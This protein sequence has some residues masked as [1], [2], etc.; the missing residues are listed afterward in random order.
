MQGTAT[1]I[2]PAGGLFA[3]TP[4]PGDPSA[5]DFTATVT[6]EADFGDGTDLGTV[7]GS[8]DDF[9]V[10]GQAKD[11]SV[12]LQAARIGT[13]GEIA[14]GNTDTALTYWTIGDTKAQTTATWSGQFHDAD[15]EGTPVV[16][17]GR[18]EAVHGNVGRMIGAFGTTRQP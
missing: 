13:N 12:E 10:N 2:G 11:W 18:F 17:T 1:Y 15:D 9:M 3:I 5:G 14:S 6:L 16:A 8:V 4:E 7:E